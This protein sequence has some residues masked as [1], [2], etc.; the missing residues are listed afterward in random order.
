MKAE[1]LA[2]TR[3]NGGNDSDST[4]ETPGSVIPENIGPPLQGVDLVR[5]FQLGSPL[6]YT[7]REVVPWNVQ[8][9][10]SSSSSM[11]I[12]SKTRPPRK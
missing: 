8:R 12:V 3:N 1:N 9:V 4:F 5:I 6:V 10:V 11:F 2:E 7:E